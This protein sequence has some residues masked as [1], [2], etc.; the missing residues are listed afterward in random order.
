MGK[1]LDVLT[2]VCAVVFI[3]LTLVGEHLGYGSF[4]YVW[5]KYFTILIW[6]FA[7]VRSW[8]NLKGKFK[9]RN[10]RI[11]TKAK[12]TVLLFVCIG[13]FLILIALGGFDYYIKLENV[14]LYDI[15]LVIGIFSFSCG[16]HKLKI[17]LLDVLIIDVS[18]VAIA[19]LL[20]DSFLD[21]QPQN[22]FLYATFSIE[23]LSTLVLIALISGT[24]FFVLECIE[25]RF[26]MNKIKIP[27]I[28]KVKIGEIRAEDLYSYL[29]IES[30]L[31]LF[32]IR[33]AMLWIISMFTHR[34]NT[35]FFGAV[36][37]VLIISSLTPRWAKLFSG[38]GV[39][40]RESPK[41]YD[42][43]SRGIVLIHTGR[44]EEAIKRFD[45][46]LEINPK[47]KDAWNAKGQA[48]VNLGKFEEALACFDRVLEIS[49]RDE[50]AKMN[51]ERFLNLQ[52]T[53]YNAE[54]SLGE[55]YLNDK[56]GFSMRWPRGWRRVNDIKLS[57]EMLV[58]FMD[59][60]GAGINII[61]GPIYGTQETI[62]DL[63]NLAIRN[64][65]NLK[66]NMKSLK[67]IKVDNLEAVEAIYTALGLETKKIGFVKDGDE[68]IIT[69]STPITFTKYK[70]IFDECIHSFEFKK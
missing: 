3:P 2:I 51:K 63:E 40:T 37:G 8:M 62:E 49:P 22:T 68:F 70:P 13:I 17:E 16:M 24:V 27:D 35:N 1:I 15:I 23:S 48:L 10:L 25:V 69:C 65:H 7:A 5:A 14:L 18:S 57:P 67:R 58:Q 64:V 32:V 21:Y 52:K 6:I 39:I 34:F 45:T 36:V 33:P 4:K 44:Y 31:S 59:P 46:T 61:A 29:K 50:K 19:I 66:G 9:S 41:E 30:V 12:A 47:N 60:I 54:K 38:I 28:N 26:L 43:I 11:L 53:Y 42:E 56:Y 55:A 20:F